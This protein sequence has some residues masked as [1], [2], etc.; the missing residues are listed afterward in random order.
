MSSITNSN[1]DITSL[2]P[3]AQQAANLFLAECKRYGIDIFVTEYHRS[4][5][6][7]M[8]LF[9]QGRTVA[10]CV[11]AGVPVDF[12]RKYART[13]N[14][15]TWTLNSNHIS[16]YAWD[17]AVNPPRKLYDES[18]ISKAGVIAKTLGIEWGGD[19]KVVD[20]PH[21]QVSSSWKAPTVNKSTL[22]IELCGECVEVDYINKDGFNYVKLRVL[23]C[24]KINVDYDSVR[25]IP[26]VE[27]L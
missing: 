3:V 26:I 14:Q 8:Y 19:W 13:G 7:Q 17:I 24:K 18:V 2:Q 12:A 23:K 9:C 4:K 5:E 25:K 16:G 1:R 6:R 27:V 15:V 11:S 21:F 22:T 20:T 10:Q